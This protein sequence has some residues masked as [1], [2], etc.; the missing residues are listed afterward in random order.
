MN[1]ETGYFHKKT[2][3]NINENRTNERYD[4]VGEYT[5]I[6]P[7]CGSFEA[8]S[9]RDLLNHMSAWCKMA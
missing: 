2:Y 8:A 6:L 1:F 4:S 9:R 5:A 3:E 7:T